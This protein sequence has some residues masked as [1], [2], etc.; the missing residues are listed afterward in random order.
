MK[1]YRGDLNPDYSGFDFEWSIR[2]WVATNSPD[3][4]WDLISGSPAKARPFENLTI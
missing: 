3:F 2:G 4:E 1:E